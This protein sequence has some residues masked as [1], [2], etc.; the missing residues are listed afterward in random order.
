MTIAPVAYA[1]DLGFIPFAEVHYD[2]ALVSASG[3]PPGRCVPG[4]VALGDEPRGVAGSGL[5]P[6]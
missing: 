3:G 5:S 6:A 1:N 2:F 4:R